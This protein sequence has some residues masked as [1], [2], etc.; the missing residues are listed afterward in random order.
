MVRYVEKR[1]A[2]V[3]SF[4]FDDLDTCFEREMT[5]SRRVRRELVKCA[6]IHFF[7]TTPSSRL[8]SIEVGRITEA[9]RAIRV[10]DE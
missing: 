9:R 5:D 3:L 2:R 1:V 10:L 8:L 4:S 7:E 6:V